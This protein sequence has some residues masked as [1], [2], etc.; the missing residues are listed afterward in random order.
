MKAVTPT[1]VETSGYL[2]G[3]PEPVFGGYMAGVWMK[4]PRQALLME[5]IL[6]K[7]MSDYAG[8]A[9]E[10]LLAKWHREV[11]GTRAKARRDGWAG[12]TDEYPVERWPTSDVITG[13][14]EE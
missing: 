5:R 1:N 8:R 7:A 13:G 2:Y 4:S 6:E 3:E 10:T 14:N 12:W 11:V 9:E